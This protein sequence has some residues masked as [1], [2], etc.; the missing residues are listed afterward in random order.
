MNISTQ[1]MCQQPPSNILP[2]RGSIFVQLAA[3]RGLIWKTVAWA[4][5]HSE[6][7]DFLGSKA[8]LAEIGEK[9]STIIRASPR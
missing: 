2:I 8:Y 4:D 9:F 3:Y 5:A 1:A 7:D 6:F